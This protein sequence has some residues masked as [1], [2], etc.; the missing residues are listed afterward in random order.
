MKLFLRSSLEHLDRLERRG[1]EEIQATRNFI[2]I[3]H[4]CNLDDSTEDGCD[5]TVDSQEE[6][7]DL[8]AIFN[9]VIPTLLVKLRDR[10]FMLRPMPP[11]SL[12]ATVLLSEGTSTPFGQPSEGKFTTFT[13]ISKLTMCDQAHRPTVPPVLPSMGL[14]L[15]LSWP[16]IRKSRQNP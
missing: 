3:L 8:N 12:E 16:A 4:D 13:A 11:A 2:Q 14:R 9:N 1:R 5:T 10:L 7:N 6:F 15:N